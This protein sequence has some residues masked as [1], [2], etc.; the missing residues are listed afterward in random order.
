[1]LLFISN[2]SFLLF[3][4]FLLLL[5]LLRFLLPLN[6]I[7]PLHLLSSYSLWQCILLWY[8]IVT[9]YGNRRNLPKMN[10]W[11][12]FHSNI[13][14]DSSFGTFNSNTKRHLTASVVEGLES[15]TSNP[16]T[17]LVWV[18]SPGDAIARGISWHF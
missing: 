13:F 8:I 9:G 17:S 11:E 6:F 12:T 3:L 16:V 10:T 1:V 7:Y 5:F 18:R 14:V 4:L 2:P 15:I